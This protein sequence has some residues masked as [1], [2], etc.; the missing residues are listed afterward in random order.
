M[1]IDE[2]K[3]SRGLIRIFFR[4]YPIDL[5]NG[6]IAGTQ[7]AARLS[8]KQVLSILLLC[9]IG[10]KRRPLNYCLTRLFFFSSWY[11]NI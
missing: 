11:L 4:F 8:S 9:L 3:Q 7:T 2:V 10:V 5:A 6:L 1:M